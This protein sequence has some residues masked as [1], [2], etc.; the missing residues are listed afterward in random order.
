MSMDWIRRNYGVP[1]KV[2]GKVKFHGMDAVITSAR[3]HY[4][5]LKMEGAK[6][7]VIVH[8]VWSMEYID[9]PQYPKVETK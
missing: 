2:G 1:A 7:S 9:P 6:R 3:G 8:P 5:R 4:L